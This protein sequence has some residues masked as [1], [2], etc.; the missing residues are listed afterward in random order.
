MSEPLSY[1]DCL[2]WRKRYAGV[3]FN[4]LALSTAAD[5]QASPLRVMAALFAEAERLRAELRV[6]DE[7]QIPVIPRA[8]Q[9]RLDAAEKHLVAARIALQ[10][11]ESNERGESYSAGVAMSALAS[12]DEDRVGA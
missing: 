4:T 8:A 5:G 9:A 3:P 12:I 7:S 10:L 1:E 2:A 11:I 6:R